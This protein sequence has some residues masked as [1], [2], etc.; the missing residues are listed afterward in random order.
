[1]LCALCVRVC[2]WACGR[3]CVPVSVFV[4][5]CRRDYPQLSVG[6][7]AF[8]IELIAESTCIELLYIRRVADVFCLIM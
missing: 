5:V 3:V 6:K 1:M 8:V 2:V 4:C 7:Q